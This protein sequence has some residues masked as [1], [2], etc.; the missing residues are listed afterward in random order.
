MD[1]QEIS[2]DEDSTGSDKRSTDHLASQ[3][4]SLRIFH[5]LVTLFQT[6]DIVREFAR[7]KAFLVEIDR[8]CLF[9]EKVNHSFEHLLE[10]FLTFFFFLGKC[11]NAQE[12]MIV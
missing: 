2:A 7:D 4:P 12:M 6:W 11:R 3:E 10:S 5:F 9:R 8:L 1:P